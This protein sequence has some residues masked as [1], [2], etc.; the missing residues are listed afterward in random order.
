[1]NLALQMRAFIRINDSYERLPTFRRARNRRFVRMLA[2]TLHGI[3]LHF[4]FEKRMPEGNRVRSPSSKG[5]QMF[6]GLI[7]KNFRQ[8]ARTTRG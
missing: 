6:G 3:Y 4:T 5:K 7:Y 2:L 8:A 1:M